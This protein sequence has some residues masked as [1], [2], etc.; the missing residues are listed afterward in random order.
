MIHSFTCKNFYSF[1]DEI[2]ISLAV[3]NNAPKN[4]GYFITPFGKRLMK[5]AVVI[6]PNASGKTHLLKV[7]PLFK[8][9]ITDSFGS[10]P[11]AALPFMPFWFALDD[12]TEL[13]VVF[14][15]GKKVYTY[16]FTLT[17][18]QILKE[19]LK[20]TQMVK[21]KTSTKRVFKREWSQ[22]Q[23]CYLLSR[24]SLG[25]PKEFANMLRKNASAVGMAAK[26]NNAECVEITKFWQQVFFNVADAN[27]IEDK[28]AQPQVPPLTQA[29]NFYS[30]NPEITQEAALL[31]SRLDLGIDDFKVSKTRNLGGININATVEHS[32]KGKSYIQPLQYES[33]G[34]KQL[35][36][37][38]QD[39]LKALQGGGVA[40][41]DEFEA[42]LHSD[43]ILELLFLFINPESNPNNAQLLFSS[44]SHLLLN[45][46]DK[47]QIVLVEKDEHGVSNAWRLDEMGGIRPDENHYGR[48]L[49]GAYG[50][51]PQPL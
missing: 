23:E 9:L 49:A 36:I 7:L 37:M 39:I 26:L 43:L 25:L 31:L 30:D 38:M 15:V 20:V 17:L 33:A 14:E 29:L 12:P 5:S 44:H 42:L 46:M 11:D 32:F 34:T 13:R 1:A 19:E 2:D 45:S 22:E 28:V 51:I 47:Q 40:I 6:G 24:N 48:Y 16:G 4:N 41:I 8:W 3:N 18:R 35:V 27:Q 10:D 21:K 50:A